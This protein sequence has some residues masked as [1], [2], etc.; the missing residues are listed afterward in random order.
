MAEQA[1]RISLGAAQA[2]GPVRLRVTEAMQ[3]IALAGEQVRLVRDGRV[4]VDTAEN[5]SRRLGFVPARGDI[6]VYADRDAVVVDG[7]EQ[8]VPGVKIGDGNAYC[9]DL[10]FIDDALAAR[11]WAH[12]NDPAAHVSDEDRA[13]WNNKLNLDLDGEELRLTRD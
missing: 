13:F 6:I 7:E 3:S 1:R 5:W 4:L 11:L 10:P 12:I 9:A 8:P 2:Q